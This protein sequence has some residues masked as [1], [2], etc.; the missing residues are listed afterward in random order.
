MSNVFPLMAL[1]NR[2]GMPRLWAIKIV[3]LKQQ[4]DKDRY[5]HGRGNWGSGHAVQPP[6]ALE[7]RGRRPPHFELRWL[8]LLRT[9]FHIQ[10]D[11]E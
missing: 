8:G 10:R 2:P 11:F 6:Q 7:V 3:E 5:F 9:I 4:T 1:L